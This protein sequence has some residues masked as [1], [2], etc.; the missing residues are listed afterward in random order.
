MKI[1]KINNIIEHLEILWKH[2]RLS[3][4]INF[5]EDKPNFDIF[6][7]NI[8]MHYKEQP[9][10]FNLIIEKNEII[11]SMILI[12]KHNPY[13]NQ[14]YGEVWYIYIDDC[15]RKHGYGTKLLD[16]ADKY[17]QNVKCEYS[18]AGISAFNPA[19]NAL[20]KRCGYEIKRYILE[21][22]YNL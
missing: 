4:K 16:F 8:L 6:K 22:K 5:P 15:Y 10:G 19:S 9:E 14:K 12:T 7:R 11:G 20:F 21:K 13:R 2:D 3:Q 18:L 1:R 17:F